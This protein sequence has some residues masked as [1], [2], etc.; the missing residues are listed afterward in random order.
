MEEER[1]SRRWH[2]LHLQTCVCVC[3][4][5]NAW[6]WHSHNIHLEPGVC[7]YVN[8]WRWCNNLHLQLCMCAHVHLEPGVC[9][10]VNIWRWCNNLHL[11]LCMCAHV[12]AWRWHSD[13][14]TISIFNCVR[15]LM[16]ML[17]STLK[18]VLMSMLG[19]GIATI[20]ILTRECVCVCQ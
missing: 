15:V 19:S 6:R 10:Y 7:A 12:H 4:P 14:A 11:Q 16:S 13:T 3:A 2:S 9:A 18:H 17:N 20:F 5:V 8:I 1:N